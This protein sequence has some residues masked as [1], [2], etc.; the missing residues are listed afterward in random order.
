MNVW[1][2][3]IAGLINIGIAVQYLYVGRWGMAL[4]FLAYCVANMG[5]LWDA[6]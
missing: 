6:Q 4:T 5:L 2:L 3:C 1:L